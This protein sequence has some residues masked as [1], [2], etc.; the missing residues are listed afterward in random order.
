MI[1][2]TVKLE[3]NKHGYNQFYRYTVHDKFVTRFVAHAIRL[4]SDLYLHYRIEDL[5][6]P[7][8]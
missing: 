2:T 1:T 3:H 4:K 6:T 5:I 7:H 8:Y